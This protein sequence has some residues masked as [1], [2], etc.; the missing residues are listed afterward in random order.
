MNPPKNDVDS[1]WGH[2]IAELIGNSGWGNMGQQPEVG[3]GLILLDDRPH[4]NWRVKLP[5][6]FRS[7]K[8]WIQQKII[9]YHQNWR[10][11]VASHSYCSHARCLR[12]N[13]KTEPGTSEIQGA[14]GQI[15]MYLCPMIPKAWVSPCDV[16]T[17]PPTAAAILGFSAAGTQEENTC[18]LVEKTPWFKRIPAKTYIIHSAQQQQHTLG[19]FFWWYFLFVFFLLYVFRGQG[20]LEEV[21]GCNSLGGTSECAL[22]LT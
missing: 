7:A 5:T 15:Y 2:M 4:E 3:S 22:A 8:H 13:Y 10:I 20:A 6:C 17:L 18:C 9:W 12:E 14:S 16:G 19:A 11:S 21:T 1:G